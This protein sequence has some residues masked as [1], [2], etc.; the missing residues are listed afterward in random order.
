MKKLLFIAIAISIGLASCT[1]K[2]KRAQNL[3]EDHLKETLHDWNS[4]ESVKFGTLDST[5][6]TVLDD[7][8]YRKNYVIYKA[9]L[10]MVNETINEFDTYKGLSSDW[11]MAKRQTLL[12]KSKAYLDTIK[13]YEPLYKEAESKFIPEFKGWKMTHSFRANNAAGHKVIGHYEY[14]F[15]KDLTKLT[16]SLDISEKAEK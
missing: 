2:E 3:I 12:D 15:D 9:Y 14:Y 7:S 16:G 6:T 5:F 10:D 4:Y 11:A 8:I 1:S 13:Y